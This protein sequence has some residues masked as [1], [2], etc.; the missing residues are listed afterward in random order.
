MQ[1]R[2]NIIKNP[3]WKD[4][5]GSKADVKNKTF[6]NQGWEQEKMPTASNYTK[7]QTALGTHS[8]KSYVFIKSPPSE[9]RKPA[10][11]QAERVLRVRGDG[12]HQENKAL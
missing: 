1:C 2:F 12:G 3:Q 6:Y 4:K 10:E 11:E 5:T 7:R 8:S 9:L